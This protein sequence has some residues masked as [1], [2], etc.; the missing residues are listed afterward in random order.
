MTIRD[1]TKRRRLGFSTW[2]RARRTESSAVGDLAR[3]VACDPEWPAPRT[4]DQAREHL[5]RK[6]ACAGALRAL[7]E[8]WR[9]WRLSR[10]D[11]PAAPVCAPSLAV[12]RGGRP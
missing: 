5:T 8:A 6:R 1:T 11:A 10:L 12:L 9:L 4:L 2:L 7:E 3:D